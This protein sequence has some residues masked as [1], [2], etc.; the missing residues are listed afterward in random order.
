M[1]SVRRQDGFGNGVVDLIP[2]EDIVGIVGKHS[3]EV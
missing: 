3:R 2:D 1:L